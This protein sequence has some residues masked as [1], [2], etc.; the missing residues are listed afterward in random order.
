MVGETKSQCN[1]PKEKRLGILSKLING[2]VL[3]FRTQNNYGLDVRYYERLK[4]LMSKE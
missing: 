4:K 3:Q 2:R 1:L